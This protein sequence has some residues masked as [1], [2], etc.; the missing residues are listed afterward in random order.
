MQR[1]IQTHDHRVTTPISVNP[2]AMRYPHK[3]NLVY[4]GEDCE[5]NYSWSRPCVNHY[6][7][8]YEFWLPY[9]R[10][11]MHKIYRRSREKF[12]NGYRF[13]EHF[14]IRTSV[15][16]CAK[17][18]IHPLDGGLG[19][20]GRGSGV[21]YYAESGLGCRDGVYWWGWVEVAVSLNLVWI[22][23][24]FYF[25]M[26][27]FSRQGED[28]G[29]EKGEDEDEGSPNWTNQEPCKLE[30]VSRTLMTPY[31]ISAMF[32]ETVLSKSNKLISNIRH[33]RRRS[34]H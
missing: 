32:L 30:T 27:R 29:G 6:P 4:P 12:A 18:G 1:Q 24:C 7:G 19:L 11:L 10:G 21:W 13:P 28:F 20:S 25:K 33:H 34:L 31:F 16:L 3:F 5:A 2:L 17:S 14:P 22:L 8:S 26:R 15:D 9:T 23:S